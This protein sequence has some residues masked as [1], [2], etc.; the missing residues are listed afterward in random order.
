[1]GHSPAVAARFY[2]QARPE[3]AERAASEMT[4]GAGVVVGAID[5][6]AGVKMGAIA[7]DQEPGGSRKPS[8]QVPEGSGVM[9]AN[10]GLRECSD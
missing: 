3:I 1:M 7:A 6:K 10:D 9:T 4:V 5:A 2:A 8:S